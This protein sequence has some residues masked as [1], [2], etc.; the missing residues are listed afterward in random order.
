MNGNLEDSL[1]LLVSSIMMRERRLD[2][3]AAEGIAAKLIDTLVTSKLDD[4]CCFITCE[5]KKQQNA[6]IKDKV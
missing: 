1:N 3:H 5:L 4:F 2:R 6:N